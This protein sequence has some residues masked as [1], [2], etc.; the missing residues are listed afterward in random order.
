MILMGRAAS[1]SFLDVTPLTT[2]PFKAFSFFLIGA[3]I[4]AYVNMF[5]FRQ[6]GYE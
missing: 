5:A 3:S 2:R 4:S 1:G 6:L